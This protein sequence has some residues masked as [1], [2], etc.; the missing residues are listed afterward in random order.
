MPKSWSASEIARNIW[1]II[2]KDCMQMVT[3][4]FR[5]RGRSP[6]SHWNWPGMYWTHCEK[7]PLKKKM[8][9]RVG[10]ETAEFMRAQSGQIS[11]ITSETMNFCW[12]KLTYIA[13]WKQ[14]ASKKIAQFEFDHRVA[15]SKLS[16]LNWKFL[17]SFFMLEL[18]IFIKSRKI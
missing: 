17:S 16:K 8:A 9:P 14:K 1:E 4:V 6:L 18:E 5:K 12:K 3:V 2:A 15:I 13:S 10:D 7:S 11:K